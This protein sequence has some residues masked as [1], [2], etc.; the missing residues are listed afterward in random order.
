MS[1]TSA[2]QMRDWR[3][4]AILAYGFRP[5]F[6]GAALWAM[7]AMALWVPMLSGHFVMPT[8]FDPVSWHAHA[9]LFGYLGA[10]IAGFLLTAVPNW[11]GRLPIVGWRLG[12]L[13]VV[14]LAG[15][16]AV[17]VSMHL[18]PVAVALTDLAFPVAICAVIAREIVAGRNWR[19]LVVLGMLAV[20]TL[21]NGLFHREAALGGGASQGHGLRIGL[22]AATMMIAVIGGR[23]VPSFTRNWLVKRGSAVLPAPPMQRFDRMALGVLLAALLGW[24]AAPLHPLTGVMLGL[25]GVMHAWRLS[26]WAGHRTLAEPLVAVLHAGYAFVPLGA[27]A[28]AV[29]ILS[30]GSVGMAGAQHLWMAGAIGLMSLA[31][32]TRATLGHTGQALT[33]GPGT[34]AIYAALV[35]AVLARV[36]AGLW[37]ALAGPLH[38][39]GGSGWIA[40]FG[41]FALVYGRL[42]L[43]V[44]AGRRT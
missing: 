39:V 16:L 28:L 41:G 7:T 23:I 30:P 13:A 12:A 15:R 33:A 29:E 14:W 43:R 18:P 26:R 32:M 10:V 38:V 34:V 22:A 1:T 27:V 5:F 44:P 35:V 24:V 36:A 17:L 4:P 3:G 21:G 11:T 6:F 9:F 2:Q 20:F 40:A 19:N 37:P 25:A 31:V 8:A 42:L